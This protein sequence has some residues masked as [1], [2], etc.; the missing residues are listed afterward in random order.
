MS[1]KKGIG[2]KE[3]LTIQAISDDVYRE[4]GMIWRKTSMREKKLLGY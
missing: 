2:Q 3:G 4:I 1:V